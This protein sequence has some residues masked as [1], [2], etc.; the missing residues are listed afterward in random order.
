MA[1]AQW[2]KT[3]WDVASSKTSSLKGLRF[4]CMYLLTVFSRER[5]WGK[6]DMAREEAGKMW[7]TW[8]L[9]LV[10][11]HSKFCGIVCT[12][13]GPHFRQ[14]RELGFCTHV[15][16]SSWLWA[17]PAGKWELRVY[18]IS[19]KAAL[20]RPEVIPP[21]RTRHHIMAIG[22]RFISWSIVNLASQRV[23]SKLA[24]WLTLQEAIPSSFP[25]NPFWMA[26]NT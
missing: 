12:R 17:T 14:P 10:W 21:L 26:Q 13:V 20:L 7:L 23:H 25:A 19:G 4:K 5:E 2:R 22:W 24:P 18:Y 15:L 9:A 1:R 11:S 3:S 16:L 6:Q 8:S